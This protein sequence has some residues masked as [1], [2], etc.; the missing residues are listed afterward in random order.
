[1]FETLGKGEVEEV[2]KPRK[3][4]FM[5]SNSK[6][7]DLCWTKLDKLPKKLSWFISPEEKFRLMET[8]AGDDT[9]NEVARKMNSVKHKLE[10]I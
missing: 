9:V 10:R 4:D 3:S 6:P 1:M 5:N 8:K 2:L 7:I